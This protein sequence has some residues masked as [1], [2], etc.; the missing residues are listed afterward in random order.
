MNTLLL[1]NIYNIV[2]IINMLYSLYLLFWKKYAERQRYF[3][4]Y[5]SF[6]FFVD[7]FV[8]YIRRY[9]HVGQIY[10][11]FP[12]CIFTISYFAYFFGKDYK[13]NVN[14]TILT[15]SAL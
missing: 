6:V 3:Y 2:V 1:S 4:L 5:I 7:V 11:Y 9:F 10:L 14:K 8:F 15:R 13:D 12:L